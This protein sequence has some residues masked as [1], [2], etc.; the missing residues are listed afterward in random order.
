MEEFKDSNEEDAKIKIV[1]AIDLIK[2][3]KKEPK[4]KFIWKGIPEGSCGLISGVAKTG[5]TTFAE[6]LA[7]SISVGKHEFYGNKLDGIPRKILFVNL[8][9][10]Y[11]LRSARNLEQIDRLSEMEIELFS[12]NY[13]STPEDFPEFLN[14]DVDWILL[15]D[16]ITASE[17]EIIFIDSLGHMC[18]GEIEK[19]SVFQKFSQTFRKYIKSLN[20]TIIIVHHNVKGNDK[21]TDQHNLA[22]SRFVQQ[23]FEFA[24]SFSPIPTAKGGNYSHMLFNKYVECDSREATLYKVSDDRWF[25]VV[26]TENV[27]KI[28][29]DSSSDGRKDSKNSEKMKDFLVSQYSLGSQTISSEEITKEFVETNTMS[30][31]TCY[32]KI[33]VLQDEG[34]LE[35]T[36]KGTYN[37]T[38]NTDDEGRV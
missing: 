29:A 11:R 23:E 2:R 38:I 6:N 33:K 24:F 14:T 8:E 19:S 28:Y 25:E 34:F 1:K 35:R 18:I 3:V 21:P 12:E 9:E 32:K 22:G 17:A 20:K 13:I 7:I 4:P 10:S 27:Y 5:K 30:K 15:R 37:I 16:Y 36:G 26:G 31:D